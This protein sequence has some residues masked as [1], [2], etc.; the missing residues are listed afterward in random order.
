VRVS[1]AGLICACLAL[2]ATGCPAPDDD[3]PHPVLEVSHQAMVFAELL[4]GETRT[5]TL[6]VT[7]GG[8][9]TLYF[10]VFMQAES[11]ALAMESSDTNG[12]LAPGDST[13]A[14]IEF[15]PLTDEAA[16]AE[17][18]LFSNDRLN[19][20]VTIPV[21]GSSRAPVIELDPAAVDFGVIENGIELEQVVS[22]RNVGSK[23]LVVDDFVFVTT[24][25]EME[26]DHPFDGGFTLAPMES[27][28]VVVRYTPDDDLADMGYLHIFSND[29]QNPDAVT[30][31]EG[32]GAYSGD[33]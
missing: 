3:Y 5:Q 16:R 21:T 11:T 20:W 25:D 18:H 19:S 14:T 8:V 26:A 7:N 6:T 23:P 24:S 27:E 30:V 13:S 31:L 9:D 4:A 28:S 32:N 15:A 29:L 12:I 1:R 2:L 10:S 17:L 33:K 22:I